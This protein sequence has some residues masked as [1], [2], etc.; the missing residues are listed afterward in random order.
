MIAG[1]GSNST[2]QAIE[3][4]KDAEAGG[5][6]AV[7]SVVPYYNKPT[8]AGLEA[9][10]RAIA[11]ASGLPMILY[12][13]PSRTACGLADETIARLAANPQ[14][15]GLKDA[16]GDMTRLPRLR[17]LVGAEFPAALRRRPHAPSPSSRRAA[18]AASP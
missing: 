16:T 4:T 12:D 2:S 18:T 13:V 3:F 8:Q 5:A 11:N 14:I 9:H 7:L 1:A 17:A 10:F 15:I 6:D